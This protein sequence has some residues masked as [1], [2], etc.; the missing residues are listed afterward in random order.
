MSRSTKFDDQLE[1]V[2]GRVRAQAVA[3]ARRIVGDDAED[4]V[5][6]AVVAV[7]E[8]A[9]RQGLEQ[10]AKPDG[11]LLAAAGNTARRMT[12]RRRRV[13][14]LDPA[15]ADAIPAR[16]LPEPAAPLPPLQSRIRKVSNPLARAVVR[17]RSRGLS[18]DAIAVKLGKTAGHCR[19]L[20]HRARRELGE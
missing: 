16:P 7:L 17:F 1:E 20:L 6:D 5:Q 4:A 8:M 12:R 10:L 19:V 15:V 18:F 11:Y 13:K 2:Y 14:Q 3:G 9:A